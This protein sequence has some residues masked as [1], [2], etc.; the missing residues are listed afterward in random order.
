MKIKDFLLSS[1]CPL[2][3]GIPLLGLPN[4]TARILSPVQNSGGEKFDTASQLNYLFLL[5][6]IGLQTNPLC[7]R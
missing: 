7:L 4:N 2:R 3:Q 1:L 5:L 6:S